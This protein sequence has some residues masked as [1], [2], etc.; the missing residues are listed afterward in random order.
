MRLPVFG[1]SDQWGMRPQRYAVTAL[2]SSRWTTTAASSVG[3]RLNRP[4]GASIRSSASKIS[5]SSELGRCCV[6]R[7]HMASLVS[8]PRMTDPAGGPAADPL[9]DARLD[10]ALQTRGALDA[11]T[12]QELIARGRERLEL[13]DAPRAVGD[14]R[15]VVGQADPAITAA[16]LLGYGDALFR[17]DD[18]RQAVAAW[19]AVV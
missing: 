11:A 6:I 14:F 7:P 19:E 4:P 13:G 10:A 12:A 9:Q 5:A 2:W 17:L 8:S 18:E 16:A 1:E 3:A 15:R